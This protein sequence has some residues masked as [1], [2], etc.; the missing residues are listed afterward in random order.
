MHIL[1]LVPSKSVPNTPKE[2]WSRHKSSMKYL[3][4]WGCPAHVLKGKSDK[5]EAK[6]KVCIFLGYSMETKGYLFY[7][8]KDNKVFVNTNAKFLE[9]DYVNNFNPRSKIVLAKI[10]EPII[11]QP[12]D[13]T[14][15]DVAV[16]DTPQDITQKMTSTQEP[17]HNGRIIRP[18]I[19]F[20]GLGETYEAISEEAESNP[21]TYEEAMKDI[22]APH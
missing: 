14:R 18:P 2:L 1:N 6:T 8:H 17:R 16:L 4:I 15:D 13:E 5:L 22:D 3:H 11:E 20:L 21:Y 9:D 12:M 7:N 10:D 19:R